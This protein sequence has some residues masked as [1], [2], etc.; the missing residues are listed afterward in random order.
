VPDWIVDLVSAVLFVGFAVLSGV[1][2]VEAGAA[3]Y[4]AIQAGEEL[5]VSVVANAVL[6]TVSTLANIGAAVTS[7]TLGADDVYGG[8]TGHHFLSDDQRSAFTTANFALGSIAGAT[9]I[10]APSLPEAG[11]AAAAGEAATKATADDVAAVAKPTSR[12][13]SPDATGT[14]SADAPD[15]VGD[16]SR[17]ANPSQEDRALQPRLTSDPTEQWNLRFPTLRLRVLA[18]P[19]LSFAERWAYARVSKLRVRKSPLDRAEAAQV[20]EITAAPSAKSGSLDVANG[21]STLTS[22]KGLAQ[23]AS[24]SVHNTLLSGWNLLEDSDSLLISPDGE[25]D[26]DLF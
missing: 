6:N 11:K 21:T 1:A 12:V 19:K 5:A 3:I 20:P 23:T 22:S 13:I 15:L 10:A 14:P 9:S 4:G 24:N 26:V 8:I 16:S 25:G 18:K 17:S 2:A 7:G